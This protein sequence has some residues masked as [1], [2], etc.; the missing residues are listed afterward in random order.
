MN[1]GAGPGNAPVPTVAG[2]LAA[3]SESLSRVSDTPRLDAELLLAAALGSTRAQLLARLRDCVEA[4]G[5]DALLERRLCYEPLAYILGHWE[6]FSLEFVV[7]PPLLVPRPETEHLV[8][9]VLAHIG[10][11]DARVLEIGTGTGCV[12]VSVAHGARRAA[13]VATDINPLA[14]EVAGENAARHG[15]SGRVTL[16]GGS[17]FE[18]VG[19]AECFDAVCSNP[20]YVE[21]GEWPELPPVIRLHED[22]RALLGGPDGL[23][24]VRAIAEGARGHLTPGGLLAMEI[25]MGQHEAVGRVLAGLGYLDVR[26]IRDLAGIERIAC[27]LRHG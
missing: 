6:F 25:G 26:F 17:L 13:V 27:G 3:A 1:G 4:P 14:L 18:P 19:E 22:P 9:A 21:D 24:I 15:V 5:F 20:P 7:K 10:G 16:R 8:E 23:D 11:R 12:A 2:R